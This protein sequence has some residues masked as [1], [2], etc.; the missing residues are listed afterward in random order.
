MNNFNRRNFLMTAS[1]AAS[2]SLLAIDPVK[3]INPRIKGLSLAAYS[4]RS[5]MKWMKGKQ[6]SGSME[7][8]DFVE[9]A[10]EEQFDGVELTA[11]FFQEPVSLSYINQVKRKTHILGLDITGGAI[12]NNFSMTPGS[13]AAK[14]QSEYVKKW[15]D[16]Y[17]DMGAPVIRVFAG[18]KGPKGA[19]Q[20]EIMKNIT[21]N[22]N[23]ALVHAEKRGVILGMENHDSMTDMDKLLGF[24]KTVK[25]DFF[26]IT[27]DSA[28][29]K[30]DKDPY[31]ELKK[32]APYTVN[33]QV[34]VKIPYNGK[35]VDTDFDRIVKI[36]RDAE[37]AGYIV[38]EYEEKEDPRKMI[39]L[40]AR[41]LR[42]AI[43]K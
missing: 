4:L 28:N 27:W 3:R 41:E 22:V 30:N 33:A 34:K 10:A 14:Q 11:Y 25:S 12:G 31:G 1:L 15:V 36:L 43:S 19:S 40:H 24:A 8:L 13:E 39:P 21:H 7:I 42:K 20:E 18:N 6:Q 38:L 29:I 17:A 9:Y 16:I 35:H 37:Y 5:E 23:E 2:S 26:G 32:I